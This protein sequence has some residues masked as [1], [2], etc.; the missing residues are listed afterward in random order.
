[1]TPGLWYHFR[2]RLNLGRGVRTWEA[3]GQFLGENPDGSRAFSFR[4][5]A[6]TSTISGASITDQQE[7][8]AGTVILPRRAKGG[9]NIPT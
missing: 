1:M 9:T 2:Y 7:V 5:K 6:G 3:A 8:P 4:P